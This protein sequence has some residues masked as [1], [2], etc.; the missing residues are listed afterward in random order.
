MML[1]YPNKVLSH[2]PTRR[3]QSQRFTNRITFI[4]E[5][6]TYIHR[7]KH[8][9][10]PTRQK[11]DE[12]QDSRKYPRAATGSVRASSSTGVRLVAS[13]REIRADP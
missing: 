3:L 11:F 7:T 6:F 12:S 2:G 10:T 1:T 8:P 13:I 5:K 4:V 9:L